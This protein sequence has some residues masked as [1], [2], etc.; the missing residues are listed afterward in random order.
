MIARFIREKKDPH[1]MTA[2]E[3]MYETRANPPIGGGPKWG[4]V[5]LGEAEEEE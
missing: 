1:K 2:D 3:K 5:Y 4:E